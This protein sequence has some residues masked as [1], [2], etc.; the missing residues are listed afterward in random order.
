MHLGNRSQRPIIVS[1]IHPQRYYPCCQQNTNYAV[2]L[3]VVDAAKAMSGR[4]HEAEDYIF[5]RLK[6]FQIPA[7]LILNKVCA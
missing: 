2:V 6:E 4:A 5:E 1:R 7:T 3:V